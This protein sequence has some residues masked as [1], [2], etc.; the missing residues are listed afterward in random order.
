MIGWNR[1]N[2]KGKVNNGES[3]GKKRVLNS[4]FRS[5]DFFVW[6]RE[7]SFAFTNIGLR[8]KYVPAGCNNTL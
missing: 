1:K 2:K 5:E 6:E 8:V 4:P 3:S 7:K